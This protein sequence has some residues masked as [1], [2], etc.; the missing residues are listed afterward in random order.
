METLTLEQL[1]E[2]DPAEIKDK[3]FLSEALM[4]LRNA[5]D[6]KYPSVAMNGKSALSSHIQLYTAKQELNKL[7]IEFRAGHAEQPCC[8]N[9]VP[10][11][12]REGARDCSAGD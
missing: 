3:P 8:A 11:A 6:K 12:S 4:N 5:Y 7:A 9:L 10:L 1:L 2:T